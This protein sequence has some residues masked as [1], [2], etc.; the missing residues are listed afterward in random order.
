MLYKAN[1]VTHPL[2]LY[3]QTADILKTLT[4]DGCGWQTR[5]IREGEQVESLWDEMINRPEH[6]NW[7]TTDAAAKQQL[8]KNLLY[9]EADILE[10]E[11]L[12]PDSAGN[13]RF[14]PVQNVIT[15]M[16]SGRDR[17]MI[18]KHFLAGGYDSEDDDLFDDFE[19][20]YI[21]NVTKDGPKTITEGLDNDDGSGSAQQEG[22]GDGDTSLMS[23][24]RYVS[25]MW[26]WPGVLQVCAFD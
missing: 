18:M 7:G 13:G 25:G 11:M 9:N 10:D 24:R 19:H 21:H 26:L 8:P 4:H 22:N 17:P 12:F 15:L 2:D 16:E 5:D 23:Y 20:L 1:R 6:F 3:A 14:K